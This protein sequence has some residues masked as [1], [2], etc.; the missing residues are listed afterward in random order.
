[1]IVIS[2][3][4]P[5]ISLL[6][7]RQL[8]LLQKLYNK[9]LM[10]QAVYRELIENPVYINEAEIIKSTDFLLAAEVENIKSVSVLRAVT[11]LDEEESA[12]LIMYDEQKADL[13]LMDEQKGRR[14]AKRLN[15]RHIGTVGILMLAYDKG[16]IQAEKVKECI[17]IMLENKIRL[18]KNICNIVMAHVGLDI[19]Y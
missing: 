15:V 9:V 18:S 5:I 10:P 8:E 14:V 4:T 3:T 16:L 6:K 17:D 1:M 12:A 7:A 2:D 19:Q 11:G 13:L